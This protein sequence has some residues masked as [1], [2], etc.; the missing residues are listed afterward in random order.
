MSL[1]PFCCYI[2]WSF[3]QIACR[4]NLLIYGLLKKRLILYFK[5]I[6][7][8]ENKINKDKN[9]HRYTV[10]GVKKI[11][12]ERNRERESVRE[13]ARGK[14]ERERERERLREREDIWQRGY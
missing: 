1:S 8:N 10:R 3:L 6:V 5:R 4:E 12:S 13:R 7:L 11:D 14:K 9:V 2:S